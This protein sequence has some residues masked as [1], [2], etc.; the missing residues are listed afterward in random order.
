M[1]YAR[2]PL[3]FSASP[4]YLPPAA[5]AGGRAA[6][7]VTQDDQRDDQ[8]DDRAGRVHLLWDSGSGTAVERSQF[9]PL[10]G[11]SARALAVGAALVESA[12]G[13]AAGCP[14]LPYGIITT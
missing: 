5:P 12:G 1:I 4:A 8:R 10:A 14:R 11:W 7:A 3:S 2:G 13:G 9:G 6:R